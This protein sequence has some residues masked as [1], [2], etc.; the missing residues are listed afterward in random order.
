MAAGCTQVSALFSAVCGKRSWG[1]AGCLD[2]RT[3]VTLNL[4]HGEAAGSLLAYQI[5]QQAA[6]LH[7]K[8]AL[9]D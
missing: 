5:V 3:P 4:R 6:L 1:S 2:G 7:K 9:L 8:L